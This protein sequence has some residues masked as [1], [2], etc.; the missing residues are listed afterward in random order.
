VVLLRETDDAGAILLANRIREAVENMIVTQGLANLSIT[1]S[2]GAAM[3][4]PRDRDI[5]DVIAR[6]DAGLYQAKSAGRN[7]VVMVQHNLT[8]TE[9]ACD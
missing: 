6:A 7:R 2:V 5:E 3:A 1:I 4:G 9:A 8:L